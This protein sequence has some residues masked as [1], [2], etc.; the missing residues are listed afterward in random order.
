MNSLPGL[1]ANDWYLFERTD[2][3]EGMSVIKSIS[4]AT[5]MVSEADVY[6]TSHLVALISSFVVN[7]T[8]KG[9]NFA[10]QLLL[11]LGGECDAVDHPDSVRL[12]R[13]AYLSLSFVGSKYRY[14]SKSASSINSVNV[15]L[16]AYWIIYWPSSRSRIQ[17]RSSTSSSVFE[18]TLRSSRRR[19]RTS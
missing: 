10:S 1:N 7:L 5:D 14:C 16:C 19:L 15:S 3:V 6:P 12:A 17:S 4:L 13:V 2:G 11:G 18:W 9:A 8:Q